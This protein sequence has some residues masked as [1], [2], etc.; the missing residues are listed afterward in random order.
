LSGAKLAYA[1]VG[2]SRIYSF[3]GSTL[4]QMTSDDSWVVMLMK[5]A[6]LDA[7]AVEKHPMRHVLTSVVGARPELEVVVEEMELVEGQV[8][9][10]CTDGLHSAVS[11]SDLAAVL[12]S[13]T[14][15]ER[16]ADVL[17]DTAVQRDGSDNV[18]LA[19]AR[20]SAT[21]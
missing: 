15:L 8:L 17:I 3:D 13:E 19:L 7:A 18:T 11:D 16:A 21:P 20:Y 9:L 2:D 1:G 6:G 10:F 4:R 14:D 5:E 12:Q